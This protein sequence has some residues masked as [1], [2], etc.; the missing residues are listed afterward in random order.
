MTLQERLKASARELVR[1]L[2][3]DERERERKAERVDRLA[4][5]P[6][7]RFFK[8]LEDEGLISPVEMKLDNGKPFVRKEFKSCNHGG[9]STSMIMLDA[10]REIQRL[11]A[12]VATLETL[13]QPDQ[14]VTDN[15][16]GNDTLQPLY[17]SLG[18]LCDSVCNSIARPCARRGESPYPELSEILMKPDTMIVCHLIIPI[19]GQE[20]L[21]KEPLTP[22]SFFE[23]K[24]RTPGQEGT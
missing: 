21:D 20:D 13:L 4:N 7:K 14:H 9:Y 5:Q 3:E 1:L 2:E 8:K 10:M 6:I 24:T 12:R 18:L 15:Q 16:P 19:T 11:R 22:E 17:R 23:D